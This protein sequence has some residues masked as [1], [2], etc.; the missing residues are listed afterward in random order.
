[1]MAGTFVVKNNFFYS[2]NAQ[3]KATAASLL[4]EKTTDGAM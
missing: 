2:V 3:G 1:M 4:L